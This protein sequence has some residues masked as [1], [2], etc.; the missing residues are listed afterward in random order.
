MKE[1]K[2]WGLVPAAGIGVRLGSVVPKQ[3]INLL[4]KPLICHTLDTL[5]NCKYL[6][7]IIVGISRQD[8]YWHEMVENKVKVLSAY[9]FLLDTFTYL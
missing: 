5:T 1:L 8:H 7:G 6:S 2:Y 4:G 3:Y 9:R